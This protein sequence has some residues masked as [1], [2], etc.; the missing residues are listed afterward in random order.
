MVQNIERHIFQLCRLFLF[1]VLYVENFHSKYF[2]KQNINDIKV[3]NCFKCIWDHIKMPQTL[4]EFIKILL[5]ILCSVYI[6]LN[7]N[8]KS[9]D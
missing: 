3:N 4:F 8:C 9:I 1:I 6:F 2:I 7:I 5:Y